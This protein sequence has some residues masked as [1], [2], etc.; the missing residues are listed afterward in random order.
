M[1]D[2]P[3]GTVVVVEIFTPDDYAT[4][5]LTF[6]DGSLFAGPLFR[7]AENE[8]GTVGPFA[9]RR[10]HPNAAE[11]LTGSYVKITIPAVDADPIMGGW[12]D[13]GYET[14][15][16]TAEESSEIVVRGGPGVISVLRH[17]RLLDENYAPAPPASEFRGNYNVEGKW[18]WENEPF[19]AILT[20]V[21][22]EGQ[23]EPGVPLDGISIDFDRT[24]DTDSDPWASFVGI[25]EMDIG[26]DGLAAY[27]TLVASGDLYVRPTPEL[28]IH[29]YGTQAY[30]VDRTSTTFGTGKVRFVKGVNI[31]DGLDRDA[32]ES[33]GVR[34]AVGR[35]APSGSLPVAKG[36]RGTPAGSLPVGS[37]R[38]T[39]PGSHAGRG[40]LPVRDNTHATHALV[41]GKD[42]VYRQVVSPLYSTGRGRWSKVPYY[43]SNDEPLLDSVGTENL[44]RGALSREAIVLEILAGND[45]ATGLYLPYTHFAIGDIV[46]LHTGTEEADYNNQ[47]VRVTG[48][49]CVL[50]DASDDSTTDL[51][52]RSLKWIIELNGAGP[53]ASVRTPT[54]TVTPAGTPGGARAG[55][56]V[57]PGDSPTINVGADEV[58]LIWPAAEGISVS[59]GT[60]VDTYSIN[61]DFAGVYVNGPA[62]LVISQVSVDEFYF[63]IVVKGN[64]ATATGG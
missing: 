32:A 45:Q 8:L 5:Y 49:T 51:A 6:T 47:D 39:L 30:G 7:D 58:L 15:I 4:P 18:T 2:D 23:S 41:E 9:I 60:L 10:D 13:E 25:V 48:I 35:G 12:L 50:L 29:A 16:G 63:W 52:M 55:V 21:I 31:L 28:L 64:G 44:R 27:S 19:G 11:I 53:S 37:S 22:E 57:A 42:R 20:R 26:T 43:E 36:G 56:G 62:T 24:D 38:G 17:M 3:T 54:A 34:A 61:Y 33:A 1:S 14:L 59:D 46:T 40:T